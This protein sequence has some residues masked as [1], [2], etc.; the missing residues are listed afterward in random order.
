MIVIFPPGGMGLA[1]VNSK[2]RGTFDFPETRSVDVILKPTSD[3]GGKIPPEA[4][5]ED[6]RVSADVCKVTSTAPSVKLPIVN[7]AIVTV[8]VDSG[9]VA[10]A[11][12]MTREVAVVAP[13]VPVR[14]PT[15]L[16][17]TGKTGVTSA[18]KNAVG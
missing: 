3:I 6:T 15:L 7:P 10:P 5:A 8:N 13:H 2:V 1:G 12:V 4:I 18:A 17:P 9:I 16:L 14:L 11:V